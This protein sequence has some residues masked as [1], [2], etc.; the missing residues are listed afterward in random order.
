MITDNVQWQACLDKKMPKE[1]KIVHQNKNYTCT[2]Y[3]PLYALYC[4]VIMYKL[5]HLKWH[6]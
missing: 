4:H 2:Y 5:L 6:L 1:F 3:M